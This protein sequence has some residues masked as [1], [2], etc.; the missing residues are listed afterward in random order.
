MSKLRDLIEASKRSKDNGVS[1]GQIVQPKTVAETPRPP[2][3]IREVPNEVKA[4]FARAVIVALT[5]D[6][7][8]EQGPPAGLT[9][10][11]LIR[12][13]KEHAQSSQKIETQKNSNA[14]RAELP[15]NGT[16]GSLVEHGH[17]N[18]DNKS[19]SQ[20]ADTQKT[21]DG[22]ADIEALKGHLIFLAN[23]IEQKDLVAQVVR[24]IA[25]Q[26]QNSP[27]LVGQMSNADV[28]LVV[29]GL[30][31]S[32]AVA[33]RKKQENKEAKIKKGTDT[34]ELHKIFADAGLDNALGKIV[35]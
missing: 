16:I 8:V 27:E 17:G 34:S 33:A 11:A 3:Q 32:Y 15:K 18:T 1:S 25:V 35:F 4:D 22:T 24:T 2:S 7:V 19:A 14:N 9:G 23:N 21:N 20:T 28:D 10:L 29:R 6:P 12:W 26:L 31:R 30:R 13:K 5:N